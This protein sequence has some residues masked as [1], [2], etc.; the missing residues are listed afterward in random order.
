MNREKIRG[1]V[2]E[3]LAANT[4][5]FLI[6]LEFLANDTIRLTVDGDTG[7]SLKEIVRISRHIEHHSN[8][9][10]EE[11]FTLEVTSP[12]IKEPL[13]ERRQYLKNIGRVLKVKTDD[14][15][16]EGILISAD[17]VKIV[18]KWKTREP[19]PVGKG[20][21]IVEKMA[22]IIYKDIKEAKVKIVF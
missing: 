20:K 21:V 9:E 1:L 12:D 22:T 16:Y 7:V 8:R 10:E 4:S 2:Q 13:T 15:E 3:A 18:L 19:K 6:N 14:C 17:D 11:Y 5:L